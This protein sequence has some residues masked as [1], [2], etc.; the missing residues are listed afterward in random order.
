VPVLA[1]WELVELVWELVEVLELVLHCLQ[2]NSASHNLNCC[3]DGALLR[4]CLSNWQ[5]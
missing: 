3:R 4:H 2:V 5:Q 1:D